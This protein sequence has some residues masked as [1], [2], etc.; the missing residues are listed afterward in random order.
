ML[1][2]L[3]NAEQTRFAEFGEVSLYAFIGFLVVFAGIGFL[4]L[5]VWTVGK[6]LSSQNQK[7]KVDT[8]VK[9]ETIKEENVLV[10]KLF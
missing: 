3:L 10:K 7:V 5:I 8:T 1:N 2:A 4:I 9:Q 6:I